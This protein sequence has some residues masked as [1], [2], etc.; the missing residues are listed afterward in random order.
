MTYESF[1]IHLKGVQEHLFSQ[2]VPGAKNCLG[3][4]SSS[5]ELLALGTLRYLR[6]GWMLDDLL[7]ATCISK[8]THRR[9]LH[10]NIEQ[11]FSKLYNKY[12]TLPKID[13]EI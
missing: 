3:V 13:F 6:R 4:A 5:I 2:W 1:Q 11:G 7:E 10:K 9:F 12:V 8:K